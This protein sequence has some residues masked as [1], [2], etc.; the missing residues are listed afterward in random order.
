M[1]ISNQEFWP[2]TNKPIPGGLKLYNLDTHAHK[3][4][5]A[6][7]LKIDITDSGAFVL[8]SGYSS[9]QQEMMEKH[10]EIRKRS[11][12]PLLTV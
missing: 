11:A 3:D 10:P 9:H 5:L 6:D 8:H 7:K 4:I 2:G 12:E 1:T